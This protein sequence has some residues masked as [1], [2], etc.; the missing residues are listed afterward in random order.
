MKGTRI[1]KLESIW[2]CSWDTNALSLKTF[3]MSIYEICVKIFK[4]WSLVDE[5]EDITSS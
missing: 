4:F 5:N 1:K 3:C 2:V